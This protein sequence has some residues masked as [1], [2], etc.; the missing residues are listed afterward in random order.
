VL[1]R[2]GEIA[3]KKGPIFQTAAL[4]GVMG[5]KKTGELIPLCHPLGLDD[6]QIEIKAHPD[7]REIEIHCRVEV[8]AGRG[9]KDETVQT[10]QLPAGGVAA[11]A[12]GRVGSTSKLDVDAMDLATKG[13]NPLYIAMAH[14]GRILRLQPVPVDRQVEDM[15][16]QFGDNKD[17]LAV[18]MHGRRP[19]NLGS[20][21]PGA[22]LRACMDMDARPK[23][24][25]MQDEH[26][27]GWV[28]RANGMCWSPKHCLA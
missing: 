6:C 5:A 9:G 14:P 13:R 7:R 22:H 11:L 10:L 3:T 25:K 1:L 4:A 12:D 15:A 27:P 19:M 17:M 21:F 20:V 28:L 8:H 18:E 16:R 2:D 23:A 24:L 26:V